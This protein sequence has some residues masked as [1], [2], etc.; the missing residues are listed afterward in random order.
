MLQPVGFHHV[1]GA[2]MSP[3]RQPFP[4]HALVRCGVSDGHQVVG[5][6]AVR[7]EP[8]VAMAHGRLPE[9]VDAVLYNEW[10]IN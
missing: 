9:K 3:R 1:H 2:L 8:D 5:V 4:L 7:Y 10:R 6:P